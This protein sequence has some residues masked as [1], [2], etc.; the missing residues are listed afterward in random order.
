MHD[1]NACN[2]TELLYKIRI[3]GDSNTSHLP[4]LITYL[5][6]NGLLVNTRKNIIVVK[7]T[8]VAGLYDY[9][10]D[11]M[12]LKSIEFKVGTSEWTPIH[13]VLEWL[14]IKW[15]DKVILGNHVVFHI[16]P[17]VN[18]NKEVF[19]YEMLAR[20][21][22]EDGN[23][24]PPN[25]VF[26]AAKKRNRIYALDRV[27]R[28]AAVRN[29]VAIQKKVFINFIPTSIYSPEHCLK[30]T[31]QLANQ[32]KIPYSQLIFEVVETENVTD[33]EHLKKIL[34]YYRQRGLHYALDDVGEGFSTI[35][36]LEHLKPNYMKLDM[37][38][39]QGVSDDVYKQKAAQKFLTAAL[40]VGAIPLAEGIERDED[41]YWLKEIGYQLFQGY[42][43]GK[44]GPIG[45]DIA[46]G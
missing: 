22:D 36:M 7:E 42:L 39:V 14:E 3:S 35:E 10:S 16:Q 41:F 30:T 45:A 11:F 26:T 28:I 25:I 34:D 27:C 18:G 19:A 21:Q 32:L 23:S 33:I 29:A 46:L 12:D 1:C 43:F 15:I 2:P 6:S 37:K 31:I 20:F 9:F 4:Q 40:Q 8:A 24:V 38:F 17:I 13:E 5:T 44:P